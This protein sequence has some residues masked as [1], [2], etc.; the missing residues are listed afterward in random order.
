MRKQSLPL[1]LLLVLS[2]LLIISAL[3]GCDLLL[4][5]QAAVV[6][7]EAIT[8]Q[9][10]PATE[11]QPTDPPPSPTA[12]PTDEPP[13][14]TEAPTEVPA[15]TP[16][17]EPST[18]V[19]PPGLPEGPQGP[20]LLEPPDEAVGS[21]M[22]LWWEWEE[23]LSDEQWFELYIWLDDP[24]AEPEVYGWYKEPPVRVTAA[25]LLP[26]HYRWKVLVVEGQEE[27]R[28]EEVTPPSEEWRFIIVRPSVL[29][30]MT[31][32]SPVMPTRTPTP[33]PTHTNTPRPW[34]P[35]P[36]PDGMAMAT[37]TRAPVTLTPPTATPTVDGYPGVTE[38]PAQPE[39]TNTPDGYPAPTNTPA[40][41]VTSTPEGTAP[42]N[43]PGPKPSSTTE[44][45]AYPG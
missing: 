9:P 32:P 33:T 41:K 40:P 21:L 18:E 30:A 34:W 2:A 14:P 3:A 31:E 45:T 36:T 5:R 15:E 26:G 24:D 39:P 10:E 1:L 12:L 35:S 28:G 13:P 42:T 27:D 20:E 4:G 6:E 22:D 37:P 7:L 25:T 43:T 16:S 17:T 44:P 19:L 11:A 23:P 29:S 38:T 8:V